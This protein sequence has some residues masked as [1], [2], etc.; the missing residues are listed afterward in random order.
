MPILLENMTTINMMIRAQLNNT[1]GRLARTR[2]RRETNTMKT[3]IVTAEKIIDFLLPNLCT[4][5]IPQTEPKVLTRLTAMAT[6]AG[7]PIA[8]VS[9]RDIA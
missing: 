3:V 2:R 5:P 9:T 4:N 6:A 8:M 1:A 7:C